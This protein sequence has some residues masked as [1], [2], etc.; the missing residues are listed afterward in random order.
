[1]AWGDVRFVE[2]WAI[3]REAA[4]LVVEGT[5]NVFY[6]HPSDWLLQQG[7]GRYPFETRHSPGI[8]ELERDRRRYPRA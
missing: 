3:P 7:K 6:V 4:V 8:R 1:M 5:S 2:D